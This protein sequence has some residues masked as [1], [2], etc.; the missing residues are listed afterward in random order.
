VG[1]R[2][3]R[4]GELTTGSTDDS[5]RSPGSNLGQGERWGEV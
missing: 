4:R 5:N 3:G 2:G 1:E